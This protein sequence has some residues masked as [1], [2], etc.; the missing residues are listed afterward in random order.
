MT[1]VF[2]LFFSLPRYF[3]YRNNKRRGRKKEELGK[4]EKIIKKKKKKNKS[5]GARANTGARA[6]LRMF[7]SWMFSFLRSNG[8]ITDVYLTR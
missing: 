6:P 5:I 8:T 3:Q 7:L 4:R 2:L 1:I